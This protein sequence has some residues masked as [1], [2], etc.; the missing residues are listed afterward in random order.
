MSCQAAL[1][2]FSTILKE[3]V[4]HLAVKNTFT[5]TNRKSLKRL[6]FN[7]VIFKSKSEEH[8]FHDDKLQQDTKQLYMDK[9]TLVYC[10][11]T[12]KL[13]MKTPS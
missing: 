2:E 8:G 10:V 7:L 1:Q 11:Y 6:L 5:Q 4:L 3:L 12:Y 13:W 9:F